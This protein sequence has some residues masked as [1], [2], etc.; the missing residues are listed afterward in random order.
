MDSILRLQQQARSKHRWKK[1]SG[2]KK[3]LRKKLKE[4]KK[5]LSLIKKRLKAGKRIG[6]TALAAYLRQRVPASERWFQRAWKDAQMMDQQDLFNRPLGP[7]IPDCMNTKYKYVIEIDGLIHSSACIQQRDAD[8][9]SYFRSI[10]F[11]VFRI[12][13]FDQV[14][15]HQVVLEVRAMKSGLVSPE[16][17]CKSPPVLESCHGNGLA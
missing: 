7:F 11:R 16:R 14:A 4:K 13:A 12:K 8:K 5:E 10:G 17:D 2:L 9:D 3:K 1:G 15:F 6:Q